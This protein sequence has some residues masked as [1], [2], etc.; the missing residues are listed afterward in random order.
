MELSAQFEG[1]AFS[2]SI[3]QGKSDFYGVGE[4]QEAPLGNSAGRRPPMGDTHV[5]I[6]QIPWG[7]LRQER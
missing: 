5:I 6:N 3:A 7:G 2:A 4:W 1:A